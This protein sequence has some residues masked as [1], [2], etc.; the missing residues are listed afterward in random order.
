MF[1]N[2]TIDFLASTSRV[3]IGHGLGPPA[4]LCFV[5]FA[6]TIKS[7][8]CNLPLALTP[9]SKIPGSAPSLV[10][11]LFQCYID[12]S[13]NGAYTTKYTYPAHAGPPPGRWFSDQIPGPCFACAH[14]R[15]AMQDADL[16]A[17]AVSSKQLCPCSV[18]TDPILVQNCSIPIHRIA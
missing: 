15:G 11:G 16:F 12:T 7:L 1:G 10:E 3:R 18:C 17:F 13:N 8:E 5:L 14:K 4:V 6:R 2:H 9:A